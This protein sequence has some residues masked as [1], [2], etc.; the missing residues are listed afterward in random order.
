MKKSMTDYL[1]ALTENGYDDLY[2]IIS[3]KYRKFIRIY[4]LLKDYTDNII[5]LKYKE[6]S[7]KDKLKITV[8]FSGIDVEEVANKL[9][10]RIDDSDEIYVNVHKKDID[11]AIHKAE[12]DI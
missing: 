7:E 9:R 11:I 3:Q 10:L 5:M 8:T 2:N 4:W 1:Y 12:A 6:K